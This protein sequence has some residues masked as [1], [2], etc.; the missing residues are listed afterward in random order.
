MVADQDLAIMYYTSPFSVHFRKSEAFISPRPF[1]ELSDSRG[2][3][4][5]WVKE[6]KLIP[7]LLLSICLLITT[8]NARS[9]LSASGASVDWFAAIKLPD[10]F[11][12][13]YYEGSGSLTV[14]ELILTLIHF[15]V[16][17][18]PSF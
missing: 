1:L 18:L 9:C 2:T 5:V 6:M 10:D 4:L 14:L 12:Y 13:Y 15:I 7:S 3:L 16:N 8:T 17:S 11:S